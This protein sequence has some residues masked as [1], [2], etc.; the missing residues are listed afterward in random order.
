MPEVRITIR[1]DNR[2]QHWLVVAAIAFAVLMLW[3]F[4][5]GVQMLLVMSP[6]IAASAIV[7][8]LALAFIAW[9]ERRAGR[10]F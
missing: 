10:P 3:R 8:A 2:L 6:T 7:L 5:T 1:R 4:K 9:R